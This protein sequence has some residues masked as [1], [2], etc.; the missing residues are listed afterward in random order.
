MPKIR[1]ILQFL[2]IH[3]CSLD[4][5]LSGV[6]FGKFVTKVVFVGLIFGN[7]VTIQRVGRVVA[8]LLWRWASEAKIANLVGDVIGQQVQEMLRCG[9]GKRV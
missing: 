9:G 8:R 4:L 1:N 2:Q 3:L 7:Y 6:T 5:F